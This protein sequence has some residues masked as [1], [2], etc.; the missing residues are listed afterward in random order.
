MTRFIGLVALLAIA[1]TSKRGF[2]S[3]LA[4]LIAAEISFGITDIR[5]ATSTPASLSLLTLSSARPVP[6]EMIAP[7]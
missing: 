7:A 4:T 5:V 1:S 6:L 3:Y 2:D